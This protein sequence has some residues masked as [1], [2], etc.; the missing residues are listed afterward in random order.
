MRR[1]FLL[2]LALLL[3]PA[4]AHA[5]IAGPPYIFVTDTIA[6]ADQVNANF[7]A[8]YAA[9]LNRTGPIVSGLMLFSPDNTFD[10]GQTASG[11]PRDLNIARN[12]TIGGT[13]AVT[14]ASTFTGAATFNAALSLNSP[15]TVTSTTAPQLTARYDVSNRL[16]VSVASNGATTFNAVGAGQ[17][18]AFSDPVTVGTFTGS[19]IATFASTVLVASAGAPIKWQETDAAANNGKWLTQAE[20]GLFSLQ[21]VNDAETVSSIAW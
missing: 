8:V 17:A 21:A 7:A 20:T 11:R 4:A 13:L 10:I 12:A 15:L 19:G 6:D 16:E 1:C 2:L 14:G 9:A 18:F 3:V 5:Q